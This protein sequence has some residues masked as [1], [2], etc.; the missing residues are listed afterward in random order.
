MIEPGRDVFSTAPARKG[1]PRQQWRGASNAPRNGRA[2]HNIESRQYGSCVVVFVP[3]IVPQD[4][5]TIYLV[6]DDY[7]KLGRCWRETGEDRTG[8]MA[9]VEDLLKGEFNDPV[10]VVAFN[11]REGWSRDVSREIAAEAQRSADLKG[12]ELTG[13]AAEFVAS[14]RLLIR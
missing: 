1:A 13:T 2:D 14:Y 3:S 9:V 6:E 5:D 4:D 12:R 8:R 7:G 10:R 11:P